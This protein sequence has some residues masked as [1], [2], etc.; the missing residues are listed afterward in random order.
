MGPERSRRTVRLEDT[1][2]FVARDKTHLRNTVRVAEGNT[3]L[4]R[5]ETFACELDDVLDDILWRRF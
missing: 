4:G 5:C 1:E 3:D 2:N